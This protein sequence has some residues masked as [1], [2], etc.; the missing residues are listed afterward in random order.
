[1]FKPVY[2][3]S[4]ASPILTQNLLRWYLWE[5]KYIKNNTM[6]RWDKMRMAIHSQAQLSL[7]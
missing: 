7:Q 6:N 3:L 2:S 1:M 4:K 5:D